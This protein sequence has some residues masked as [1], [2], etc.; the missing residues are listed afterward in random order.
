VLLESKMREFWH[1]T[2]AAIGSSLLGGAF[3]TL[4]GWPSPE[5]INVLAQPNQVQDPLR[6]A[7][8]TGLVSGLL[9]GAAVM[10]FGLLLAALR[11]RRSTVPAEATTSFDALEP[12]SFSRRPT[13]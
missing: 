5:F 3:G 11:A 13:A 6:F 8:A 2:V 12:S 10:G 9:L 4:I 7:A 1:I